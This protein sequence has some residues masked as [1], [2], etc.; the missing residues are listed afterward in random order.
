MDMANPQD[1]EI[2]NEE[3]GLDGT[4]GQLIDWAYRY[5]SDYSDEALA[6]ISRL[7]G[8]Y[9]MEEKDIRIPLL[10]LAG[11]NREKRNDGT[12]PYEQM[13]LDRLRG[14]KISFE[15]TMDYGEVEVREEDD[16]VLIA[17]TGMDEEGPFTAAGA[18]SVDE[19][20]SGDEK[21]LENAV[22]S[23]LFYSKQYDEEQ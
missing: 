14:G 16:R 21:F 10:V 13:K 11:R 15:E 3:L 1:Y 20:M 6:E 17:I 7:A 22:G 18:Y 8:E 2:Y 4:M 5:D 23:V 19:F 12:L 9:G